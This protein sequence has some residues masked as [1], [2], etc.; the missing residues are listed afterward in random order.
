L[1]L[2]ILFQYG[3]R[4]I[5]KYIGTEIGLKNIIDE[6]KQDLNLVE[7]DL[8]L[9]KYDSD[10]SEWIDIQDTGEMKDKEKIKIIQNIAASASSERIT[11]IN[12]TDIHAEEIYNIPGM[13][14]V[15]FIQYIGIFVLLYTPIICFH[16][17]LEGGPGWTGIL[18]F[19]VF[20]S[21]PTT[22]KSVI[23]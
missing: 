17:P 10:W 5:V 13:C 8:V 2:Q 9:Q 11:N 16:S 23:C 1:S 22:G 19:T 21:E 18:H 6:L 15:P 12:I 3:S 14:T 4:N 7:G 20:S